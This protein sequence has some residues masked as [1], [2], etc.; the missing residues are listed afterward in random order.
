MDSITQYFGRLSTVTYFVFGLFR[1][2]IFWRKEFK[3]QESLLPVTVNSTINKSE[4][5]NFSS[6]SIVN[7]YNS[8]ISNN[9]NLINN[10]HQAVAPKNEEQE[11]DVNYFEDMTPSLT[12]QKK[13]KIGLL[14]IIES[15][16]I[17][18]FFYKYN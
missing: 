14:I 6:S 7:S 5:F 18:F 8:N 15:L 1:K 16:L 2:L 4:Q 9:W 17:F 11:E 12:K 13:V 3:G 10:R